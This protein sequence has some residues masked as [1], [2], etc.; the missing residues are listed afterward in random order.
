LI[1]AIVDISFYNLDDKKYK[2]IIKVIENRKT[3]VN[4][5]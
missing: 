1:V 3:E 4:Q 2:E 5:A